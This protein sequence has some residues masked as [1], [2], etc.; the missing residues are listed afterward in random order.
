MLVRLTFDDGP[1]PSTPDL[2]DVLRDASC[3]ATFFLLG[4]NLA[5]DRDTA[6]RMAREGHLL[7]NHTY[8]H[9]RAG[10]L[11]DV[12][13]AAEIEATDALIRE[14]YRDAGCDAPTGIPPRLP[15][16]VQP[17]D[18]RLPVLRRMGRESV[19]WTMIAADWHRPQPSP[20]SLLA[21]IVHH[22]ETQR[23]R[24]Q[25]PVAGHAMPHQQDG[26]VLL[27]LHDSSRHREPRPATVETVRRLLAEP[28]FRQLVG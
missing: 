23:I 13:L 28:G 14:V 24:K 15:Y 4:G 11:T 10:D 21:S 17:D 7:G 2:L 22:V 26:H 25:P 9:A 27:C 5:Q 3:K 16:G 6:V 12:E 19:G 8:T 18:P 1:G 20:A